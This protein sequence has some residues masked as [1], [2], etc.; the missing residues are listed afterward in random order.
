MKSISST[1]LKENVL[2]ASELTWLIPSE[3]KIYPRTAAKLQSISLSPS[4][5]VFLYAKYKS[6]SQ[7]R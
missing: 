1:L 4:N 5:L 7:E 6:Q 3:K 2:I